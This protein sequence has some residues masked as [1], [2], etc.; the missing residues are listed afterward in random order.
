MTLSFITVTGHLVRCKTFPG[1]SC[2]SHSQLDDILGSV[3]PEELLEGAPSGF[4]IV[5][6]IGSSI[7]GFLDR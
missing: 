1:F 5:G 2:Q 4:A 6:H 3:L 7:Y